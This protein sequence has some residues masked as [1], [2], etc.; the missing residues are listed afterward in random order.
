MVG[1]S[2]LPLLVKYYIGNVVRQAAE[3]LTWPNAGS[4][5][6]FPGGTHTQLPGNSHTQLQVC[7][8]PQFPGGIHT[9]LL[10]VVIP[11]FQGQR[12]YCVKKKHLKEEFKIFVQINIQ[13]RRDN[14]PEKLQKE[15]NNL[16]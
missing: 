13:R 2:L 5:T 3:S 14:C 6:H 16:T 4:H 1:N 12:R 10:V 11:K 7:T 8:H 9:G 15:R